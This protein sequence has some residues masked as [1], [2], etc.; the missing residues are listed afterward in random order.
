MSEYNFENIDSKK[1]E[2]LVAIL[3]YETIGRGI[4][5]FGTGTD[6]GREVTFEG[7]MD[8]PS[9]TDPW[10]G[11]L[12]VQC[13]RMES[14]GTTPKKEAEWAIAQLDD[15]MNSYKTAKVPRRLPNYFIFVTSAELSAKPKTGGKDKFVERLNYWK[16]EFNLKGVD[17]WDREMLGLMLD[18]NQEVA[19]RFGYLHSG[20]ILNKAAQ[21][22]LAQQ[23]NID[24]AIQLFLQKEL[25]NDQ[26]VSL[27][28]AGHKQDDQPSLARVFVDLQAISQDQRNVART[29]HV[30]SAVQLASDHSLV[31]K[32]AIDIR[33]V[34]EQGGLEE[35]PGYA[36]D[37]ET[38][39]IRPFM[40]AR[41][42]SVPDIWKDPSRF[43]FIG[44]P[45]QGKSTLVQ[46]LAQRHRAAMLTSGLFDAYTPDVE[47]MILGIDEAAIAL[48][49]GLPK[50]PR[51]PFR[52]VLERFADS[53]AKKEV[54][55]VLDYIA[56][57][58]RNR[59][60]LPFSR[61]DAEQVL[62]TMPVLV[63]FD[64]LDEV[65][66]TNNRKQVLDA[67]QQFLD[68]AHNRKADLLVLATTRP[69]GFEGEFAPD[70]YNHLV[71][72][73][74]SKSEALDYARKLVEAKYPTKTE[75]QE[76]VLQRL[77]KAADDEAIV[78]LMESPLQVTI[79]ALLVETVG[80]LPRERYELFRRYYNTIYEREQ[81][82]SLA[83]SDVLVRHR[84]DI[85]ILH[86][87]IG[88][89]LQIEAET[90]A[91]ARHKT[92]R[93]S[94]VGRNELEKMIAA[95]LQEEGYKAGELAQIT[96]DFMKVTL[97]RL[98]FIVPFE[99]DSYGFEVRSLQEF[100]AART[101]MRAGGRYNL[102]KER[103]RAIAPLPYWLNTLL[104]AI[105]QAFVLRDNQQCDIVMTL[106]QE[107]NQA[108]GD[109][110]LFRT[111]A[112]SR[113]A[114]NILE[115]GVADVRPNYR[116]ALL[117][118]AFKLLT[119]PHA[120]TA[121]RLAKLYTT[122]HDETFRAGAQA[123][124]GATDAGVQLS[125]LVLLAELAARPE[126]IL[127]SQRMLQQLWP[128]DAEDGRLVLEHVVK[129]L[130]WE[131]WQ[132]AATEEIARASSM[133][134]VSTK[135]SYAVPID[136]IVYAREVRRSDDNSFYLSNGAEDFQYSYYS[137]FAPF[138][139]KVSLKILDDIIRAA[140]TH[141][142][143]LL[144]RLCGNYML[145]PTAET[146]AEALEAL[147]TSDEFSFERYTTQGVPWQLT[148]ILW[149]AASKE[150][151]LA[152]AQRARN[153]AFGSSKE[154]KAAERRWAKKGFKQSDFSVFSAKEWP[155]TAAVE[156]QGISGF[157][158]Y[159]VG[160]RDIHEESEKDLLKAFSTVTNPRARPGIAEAFFFLRRVA[161]NKNQVLMPT[162]SLEQIVEVAEVSKRSVTA[163]VLLS[164]LDPE[165]DWPMRIQALERLGN[166]IS[167]VG[168]LG[169][170][171]HAQPETLETIGHQLVAFL[172]GKS[173]REGILRFLASLTLSAGYWLKLK[174]LPIAYELL[175]SRGQVA[176]T[177]IT[178]FVEELE[179]PIATL[180][181]RVAELWTVGSS[182]VDY[183]EM[184][185]ILN[186][187]IEEK[188]FSPRTEEL[189][190]NIYA[191]PAIPTE[192]K[193]KIVVNF[194]SQIK[195]RRSG[196]NDE[197]SK[198]R[199][200]LAF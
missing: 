104:F 60:T 166:R 117:E 77:R 186:T 80:N 197:V 129:V 89:R 122:A 90:D 62:A 191:Q 193:Q 12:V 79:M 27:T 158:T 150:E 167:F 24:T 4:R 7:K 16:K 100:A 22:A 95:Y 28:Q 21:M 68:E 149:Q 50:H 87:R 115:D 175:S 160:I 18:R 120:P 200:A 101:L 45:G 113:L 1:F 142:D 145:N 9:T 31:P 59:S 46:Y 105:G 42:I 81:E 128:T 39:H 182:I 108:A 71:L 103:L 124:V 130:T 126:P 35:T 184:P 155:F 98:V 161:R 162:Y 78:R 121:V 14:R 36:Y 34:P 70:K 123:A 119:I 55:S 165:L 195:Y 5:V 168:L 20:D 183:P 180:A 74:L 194:I 44:G 164:L 93:K 110:V 139:K 170:L 189:L 94:R 3:C 23:D 11:Y 86:D 88:L 91:D 127:W 109:A 51:L 99:A 156:R 83:L 188:I 137:T 56:A 106:C 173:P 125:L 141:S 66:S 140:P 47:P 131:P 132:L 57:A 13:K 136:W 82:R 76:T 67:V 196:L 41:P 72:S 163:L 69:Q 6:G 146:L 75:R 84:S 199:L 198:A 143:W 8:Y 151:L 187:L 54:A 148:L 33:A 179:M 58:I 176:F 169:D 114:L 15:E 134:W 40:Q 185:R 38:G 178:L 157:K 147:A 154:W 49:I 97:D 19:K 153:G 2:R 102:I 192:Y 10:H 37:E 111:R 26:F 48:G 172:V 144:I 171:Q 64:G 174:R 107:F 190:S 159:S 135:L 118:S 133:D 96:A 73:P 43:V 25:R 116:E 30:V 112:G 177:A 29:L 63:A 17:V 61:S 152:C 181:Q 52:I 92:A 65:P 53:L 85:E 32:P 138:P